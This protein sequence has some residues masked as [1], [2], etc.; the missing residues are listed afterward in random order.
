VIGAV[1]GTQTGSTGGAK[2]V[3]GKDAAGDAKACAG[4]LVFLRDG[5]RADQCLAFWRRRPHLRAK[6]SALDS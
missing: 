6:F 1:P 5:V 4:E 2:D 3:A